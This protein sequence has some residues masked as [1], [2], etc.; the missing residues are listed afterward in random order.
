MIQR[1][2]EG[3]QAFA[4]TYRNKGVFRKFGPLNKRR[5]MDNVGCFGCNELGHYKRDCPKSDKDKRKREEAHIL[6]VRK[7]PDAKKSKKEEGIST[8]IEII[9]SFK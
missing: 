8:M 5:N 4:A 3:N 2:S 7:G 9:F 6:D 1:P